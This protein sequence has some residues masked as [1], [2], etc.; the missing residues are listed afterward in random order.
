MIA[1]NIVTIVVGGIITMLPQLVDAVPL[2]Y[3]T[4]AS[5][6]IAAIVAW[7]HLY[8]PSPSQTSASMPMNVK[9]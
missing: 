1:E 7:W 6:I 5:G 3:R 2:E 4:L 8:Q 9:K